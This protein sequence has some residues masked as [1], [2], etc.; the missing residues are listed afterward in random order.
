MNKPAVNICIRVVWGCVH[1]LL[2]KVEFPVNRHISHL[3]CVMDN[4]K[5]SHLKTATSSCSQFLGV[6]NSGS[7]ELSWASL[8]LSTQTSAQG[9][10]RASSLRAGR[11]CL[12]ATQ[13]W[14]RDGSLRV[15]AASP[16]RFQSILCSLW[17]GLPKDMKPGVRTPGPPR[18]PA[19]SHSGF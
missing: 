4:P 14:E 7:T 1:S 11:I 15:F 12:V 2:L 13:R 10:L 6:W 18:M 3:S 9:C 16:R 8:A 17:Q 5:I 19:A